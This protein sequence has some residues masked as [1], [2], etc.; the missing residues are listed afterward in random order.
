MSLGNT[1][2]HDSTFYSHHPQIQVTEVL[3]SG[4][5]TNGFPLPSPDSDVCIYIYFKTSSLKAPSSFLL[6]LQLRTLKN[7]QPW[8]FYD[9]HFYF[10]L[11]SGA[12]GNN[13]F[14]FSSHI[15]RTHP[16]QVEVA[17]EAAFSLLEEWSVRCSTCHLIAAGCGFL[18][19]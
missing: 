10:Y 7:Q 11:F 12:L 17:D 8:L 18:I 4:S 13:S 2:L 15:M 1:L 3:V 16:F 5:K 14:N 6:E 9:A 19:H